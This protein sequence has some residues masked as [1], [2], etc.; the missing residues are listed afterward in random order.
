MFD[1]YNIL[2]FTFAFMVLDFLSGY[3]KA[4]MLKNVSST[5]MR[6]GLFHKFGFILVIVLSILIE[7][8]GLLT[9]LNLP[10]PLVGSV[11][12]YIILTE[13]TSILENVKVINP[14]LT[15]LSIFNSI[16]EPTSEQLKDEK[17]NHA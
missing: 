11:C 8:G 12:S 15:S 7:M 17:V 10:L 1:E 3:I 4:L 16:K 5:V 6:E 2:I 13:I 14:Q 9:P